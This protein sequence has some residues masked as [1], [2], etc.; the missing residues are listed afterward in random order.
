MD[1]V[2][3]QRI[4]RY[5]RAVLAVTAAATLTLNGCTI[6]DDGDGDNGGDGSPSAGL[7]S[8]P[9]VPSAPDASAAQGAPGGATVSENVDTFIATATAA[10][11]SCIPGADPFTGK[12]G[13]T[14]SPGPG[15]VLTKAVFAVF[16]RVDVADG[17]EAAR[18]ARETTVGEV[19]G[20]T[21]DA[22]VN[23]D[24]ADTPDSPDDPD[25]AGD[26]LLAGQYLPLDSDSLAGYCVNTLGTCGGSDFGG[27]GLTLG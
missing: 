5:R 6:G 24:A 14:C 25:A 11:W 13:A 4:S 10:G 19:G 26:D 17:A 8:A 21:P 22:P 2:K 9:D 27:L 3:N 12:P 16:D 15:D 7:S 18:L 20:D 1:T 23:P